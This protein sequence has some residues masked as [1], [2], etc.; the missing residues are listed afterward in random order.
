[1]PMLWQR[2]LR[3][4][5]ADPEQAA[6]WK[7]R[8]ELALIES[9]QIETPPGIRRKYSSL[10]N[11]G[12]RLG[13]NIRSSKTL[14]RHESMVLKPT[15]GLNATAAQALQDLGG[16]DQRILG[17]VP[18]DN[19][20]AEAE[21]SDN[22]ATPAVTGYLTE[23]EK[24]QY[25][26]TVEDFLERFR[27]EMADRLQSD[28][29]LA[30]GR[31]LDRAV[32]HVERLLGTKL[33]RGNLKRPEDSRK[34]SRTRGGADAYSELKAAQSALASLRNSAEKS[35]RIFLRNDMKIE[36]PS[37]ESRAQTTLERKGREEVLK[38]PSAALEV[39]A[40]RTVLAGD[41]DMPATAS[42]EMSLQSLFGEEF[43]GEREIPEVP[44]EE[45]VTGMDPSYMCMCHA[46]CA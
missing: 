17:L 12:A 1:M 3:Q 39:A 42:G 11:T 36:Y 31:R 21:N 27:Q 46:R 29:I 9:A 30:A 19:A 45:N 14:N 20:Q 38:H 35:A 25:E 44:K 10:R 23:R 40:R 8:V 15:V 22:E 16:T 5:Q 18:P 2:C 33:L 4:I 24:R 41:L 34:L 7:A 37:P 43:S 6:E 26:D 32:E 13:E 28:K